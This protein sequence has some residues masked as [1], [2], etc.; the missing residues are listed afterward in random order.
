VTGH[1][2]KRLLFSLTCGFIL[3]LTISAGHDPANV[4][5]GQLNDGPYIRKVNNRFKINWI[6][7]GTPREDYIH[8]GNF[9]EIRSAFN[10]LF[11]YHHLKETFLPRPDY[12]H[13]F[14]HAD[15]ICVISD[16]HGEYNSY[17]DLL[18][19]GS[20]IDKDLNWN[21][22]GG[23]LVVLGD[24][25]GKGDRVTE[26]YWHLYGLEKQAASA[27]GKVHV[28]LGNHELLLFRKS[29]KDLNEKYRKVESVFKKDY[30]DFYAE[31]T[32]LGRW[33]RSRPVVITI[34]NILF[35]HGGISSEMVRRKLTPGHINRIFANRIIGK[36]PESVYSNELL[37]F[38]SH[39]DGPLWYRGYFED[40]DFCEDELQNILDFYN[41]GHII[42]GHTQCLEIETIFNNRIIGVDAG[43]QYKQSGEMLIYSNGS[44]YRSTRTGSRIRLQPPNNMIIDN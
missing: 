32:V 2:F 16:I 21:F 27:G 44:F 11:D 6:E 33:L 42:V 14:N 29:L 1:S 39:T 5:T 25:S 22:G 36:D 41:I 43:L 23:H 30:T 20:I 13:S 34:N 37:K 26:V 4:R 35:V 8:A 12:T 40:A 38:L 19:A 15:S 9:K 28:L 31:N 10:L 17:I 7:N 24:I 18:K 3:C